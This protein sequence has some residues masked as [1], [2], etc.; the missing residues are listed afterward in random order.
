[1]NGSLSEW[2]RGPFNLWRPRVDDSDMDA[3]CSMIVI[4]RIVD[5]RHMDAMCSMIVI[6]QVFSL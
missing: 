3:T 6:E 2:A 4:G 5:G 1:L